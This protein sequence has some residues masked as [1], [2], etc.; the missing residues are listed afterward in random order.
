MIEVFSFDE[1]REAWGRLHD[2]LR[3]HGMESAV[4]ETLASYFTPTPDRFGE[5][6]RAGVEAAA[7]ECVAYKVKCDRIAVERNTAGESMDA[8][9]TCSLAAELL[10]RNIRALQPDAGEGA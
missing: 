5:G 10:E 4:I 3:K 2:G 7:G 9:I 6:Y 8:A 1:A